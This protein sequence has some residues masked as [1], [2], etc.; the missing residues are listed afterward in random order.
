VAIE[1]GDL[2]RADACA[3]EL[4]AGN[5]SVT[6]QTRIAI[7]R[8]QW[9]QAR[10]TLAGCVPTTMRERVDVAVL[11]ARIAHGRTSDDADTLLAAALDAA[12]VEGFVVAVTDDMVELRPRV[13]LLLRSSHLGAF[14]QA[15]LDRL[16]EGVP[17]AKTNEGTA[18]PLS[19]RELTVVR[20]LASRLTY[21]EIAAEIFV[22]ANT[23]KTH[24]KRIYVKLGVSSRSEAVAEAHRLDIL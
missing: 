4:E 8:G 9:D 3:G 15:V 14:E 23:L 13:A 1:V 10:Q 22:S 16:D 17:V 2:E 21:K 5:R 6:L 11:A 7:A 18:G 19:T 12:K 20:Y 24:I